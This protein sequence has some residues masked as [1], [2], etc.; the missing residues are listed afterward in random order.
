MKL[1][2]N[3]QA[4]L[5]ADSVLKTANPNFNLLNFVQQGDLPISFAK[6]CSHVA[7]MF[8]V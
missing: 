4:E 7:S 5:L 8:I 1:L 3:G 6:S 2:V